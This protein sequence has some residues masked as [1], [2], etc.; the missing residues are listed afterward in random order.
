MLLLPTHTVQKSASLR[1]AGA[2]RQRWNDENAVP[3]WQ[4]DKYF[5]I[6]P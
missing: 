6:P 2:A 5:A 1:P 3:F 4:N